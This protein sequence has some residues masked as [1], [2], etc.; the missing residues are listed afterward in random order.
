MN[1]ELTLQDFCDMQQL[2]KLLDNWSK[3]SGMSAALSTT[4]D[5]GFPNPLA[6]Q[7]FAEWLRKVP[8]VMPTVLVK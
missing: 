3:S 6:S 4:M 5:R 2:Y 7:S 1:E 8:W